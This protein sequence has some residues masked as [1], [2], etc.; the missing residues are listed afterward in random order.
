MA[1][2]DRIVVSCMD[3]RLSSFLDLNYNDSKTVF[4]RN[5]GANISTALNTIKQLSIEFPISSILIAPH[6][7]CGAMGLVQSAIGGKPVSKQIEDSLVAQF[8]NLDFSDRKGLESLNCNVQ[9]KAMESFAK[10]IGANVDVRLIDLSTLA[11]PKDSGRH[12]LTITKPSATKYCDFISR[13][14]DGG[15]G[16]FDSYFIQAKGIKDV[17]P[18]VEIAAS[19]LHIH[20]IRLISESSLHDEIIKSDIKVLKSQPYLDGASMSMVSK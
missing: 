11:I 15:L 9:A 10:S 19:A 5:A 12:L 18:D 8:R 17:L 16:M 1:G 7:D 4:V 2:I 14:N 3:R 6:T 20:D 13:Y